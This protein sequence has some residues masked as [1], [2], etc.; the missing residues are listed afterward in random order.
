LYAIPAKVVFTF[1]FLAMGITAAVYPAMSNYAASSRERLQ[2]IFSR[3]LQLLLT[4]SLP[5]AVGIFL[6]AEP[7]MQRIWPEFG[8]SILGLQILIWAVVFLFIEYPFGSLLNATGNERRNTWNRGI[9]LACFIILNLILIPRLGFLGAVYTALA[10]SVLIV[11]LGGIKARQIVAVFNKFIVIILLK[12]LASS[13]AMGVLIWW[14][15]D[16]Y[17]FLLVIPLA[18]LLYFIMLLVLRVYGRNDWE[19]LKSLVRRKASSEFVE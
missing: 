19:W 5:I 11:I 2:N 12:L 17:S 3:T 18:A 8:E 7:I 6:L 13:A 9:Q 15:R 10:T 4:L 14:L 16:K 1:P